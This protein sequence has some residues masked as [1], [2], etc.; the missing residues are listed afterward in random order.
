MSQWASTRLTPRWFVAKP[1]ALTPTSAGSTRGRPSLTQW[2]ESPK[3]ELNC[4][5]QRLLSVATSPA[6]SATSWATVLPPT[7]QV[8]VFL[9]CVH[10]VDLFW[11]ELLY[12]YNKKLLTWSHN[13]NRL[14][15]SPQIKE[16]ILAHYFG[17]TAHNFTVSVHCFSFKLNVSK[18]KASVGFLPN[19]KR[20]EHKL[21]EHIGCFGSLRAR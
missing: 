3:M 9:W 17:F 5:W 6:W 14:F 2:E 10:L 21:W 16:H 18:K 1:G 7:L 13:T 20:Q 15:I 11:T 12:K 8:R 4:W 19:N